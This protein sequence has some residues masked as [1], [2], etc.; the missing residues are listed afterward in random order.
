MTVEHF[1]ESVKSKTWLHRVK[2][3]VVSKERKKG[4]CPLS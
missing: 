1:E 2:V 3:S 4:V